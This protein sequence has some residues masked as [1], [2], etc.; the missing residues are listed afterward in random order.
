[1][2]NWLG[3]WQNTKFCRKLYQMCYIDCD[4]VSELSMIKVKN[5]GPVIKNLW[6][7]SAFTGQGEGGLFIF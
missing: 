7:V 2:F 6:K 5:L 4:E 3:Q 1:M